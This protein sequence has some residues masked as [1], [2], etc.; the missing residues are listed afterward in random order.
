MYCYQ[1]VFKT[2]VEHVDGCKSTIWKAVKSLL[3]MVVLTCFFEFH[4]TYFN[5]RNSPFLFIVWENKNRQYVKRVLRNKWKEEKNKCFEKQKRVW[6]SYSIL[7][8]QPKPLNWFTTIKETAVSIS[9]GTMLFLSI[10]FFTSPIFFFS[11]FTKHFNTSRSLFLE[12]GRTWVRWTAS[13]RDLQRVQAV[14]P[15]SERLL[16]VN[17]HANHSWMN[18]WSGH[19]RHVSAVFV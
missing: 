5:C 15:I 8:L 2:M 9:L 16:Q 7:L 1:H 14:F 17:D 4:L 3:L 11:K 12:C 10:Q 13:G 19:Y 18:P 6:N